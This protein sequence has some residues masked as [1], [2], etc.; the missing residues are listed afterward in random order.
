[1]RHMRDLA[2]FFELW[3]LEDALPMSSDMIDV[4][5]YLFCQIIE[6]IK[7]SII[8]YHV[9]DF[10]MEYLSINITLKSYNMDFKMSFLWL[11]GTSSEIYLSSYGDTTRKCLMRNSIIWHDDI[12][13]RKSKSMPSPITM[14][15]L[16]NY[17]HIINKRESCSSEKLFSF[18]S[19]EVTIS[20]FW[21]FSEENM[22]YT[23]TLQSLYLMTTSLNHTTDL[24]IFSFM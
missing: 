14:Y 20:P 5:F 2:R 15:Y 11:I 1:M 21:H 7:R 19:F 24:S 23:Y 22:L 12:G 18:T 16:T 3:K 17:W 13:S 10:D 6:R 9:H 4:F 8:T